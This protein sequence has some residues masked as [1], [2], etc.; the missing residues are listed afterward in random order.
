MKLI[1][2]ILL[3]GILAQAALSDTRVKRDCCCDNYN[4]C[5]SSCS[6]PC[7]KYRRTNNCN[8]RPCNNGR[9]CQQHNTP[10]DNNDIDDDSNPYVPIS[11]PVPQNQP[12][13]IQVPQG[14]TTVNNTNI[15]NNT[16]ELSLINTVNTVN[17]ISIP[18]YVNSTNEN[19]ITVVLTPAKEEYVAGEPIVNNL[20][21][22]NI[23]I[24]NCDRN[25]RNCSFETRWECSKICTGLPVEPELPFTPY[26]ESEYCSY[27]RARIEERT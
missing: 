21:C 27:H 11:I 19:T 4:D 17:N 12:N 8:N 15:N 14:V 23:T 26:P 1:I 13:S 25:N 3:L 6:T 2:S 7:N 24:R 16:L 5:D 10:C 20:N 22:C 9:N 18:I